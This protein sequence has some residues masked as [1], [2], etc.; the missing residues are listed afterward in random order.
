MN[1]FKEMALSI[2]SYGSY[3]QFLK[4]KKGKVFGFGVLLVT[5]YFA[6]IMILPAIRDLVKAQNSPINV[7]DLRLE[8]GTLWVEDVVEIDTGTTYIYIDTDPDFTIN[9]SYELER[10]LDDHAQVLLV[11]SKKMIMKNYS[12]VQEIY[13]SDLGWELDREDAKE[14]VSRMYTIYGLVM[15][16]VMIFAYIGMVG[17]FFFGVLFVALMGMIVAS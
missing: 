11:N 15:L 16:L 17:L 9:N 4:N 14:L 1:V 7:P 2:Y 5:F 12:T 6:V 8:D 10:Y 13:F 3:S